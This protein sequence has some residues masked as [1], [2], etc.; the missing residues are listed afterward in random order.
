MMMYK[1]KDW[2]FDIQTLFSFQFEINLLNLIFSV[3]A[4]F[5]K[6]DLKTNLPYFLNYWTSIYCKTLK[7]TQNKFG[8]IQITF[9]NNLKSG[10]YIVKYINCDHTPFF[11]EI[12]I[13]GFTIIFKIYDGR[14]W[15]DENNNY[16]KYE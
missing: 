11:I 9:Q 1:I 15:N 13:L 12:S 5:I 10:I 14:H 4:F 2:W 6:F 8:E 16:E 7:L 3:N